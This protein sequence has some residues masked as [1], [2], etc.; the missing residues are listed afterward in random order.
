MKKCVAAGCAA[1][2]LTVAVPAVAQAAPYLG[3][4]EACR[5]AGSAI[6]KEWTGIVPGSGRCG[7]QRHPT[8]SNIVMVSMRY[9]TYRAGRWITTLSIRETRDHYY[10]RFLDDQRI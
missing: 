5:V 9:A 1:L 8:R 3:N 2:A 7:I 10:W 4:G 6:H